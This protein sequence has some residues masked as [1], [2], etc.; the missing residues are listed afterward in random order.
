MTQK[1]HEPTTKTAN[2]L[3]DYRTH[4]KYDHS[5]K[6]QVGKSLWND[7]TRSCLSCRFRFSDPCSNYQDIDSLCDW[8]ATQLVL[9]DCIWLKRN[10]FPRQECCLALG[11]NEGLKSRCKA[12]LSKSI[13]TISGSKKDVPDKVSHVLHCFAVSKSKQSHYRL[14]CGRDT[15]PGIAGV[16][17]IEASPK[18]DGI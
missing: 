16:F 7:W 9:M 6:I 11:S 18:R 12:D 3:I 5:S 2:T 8:W 10:W 4:V 1:I 14:S 17:L 13:T 15:H